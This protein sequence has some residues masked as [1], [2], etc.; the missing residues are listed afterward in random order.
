MSSSLLVFHILLTYVMGGVMWFVQ[1]AYYPNLAVVGR[2]AFI[3]YQRAHIRRINRVAWTMLVLE[4]AT[5]IL[6]VLNP[7]AAGFRVWLA[8]NMA[9]ILATWWSTWFVQVPLHFTL[10]CGWDEQAHQRLVRTNWFRTL[11]YTA[12]GGILCCVLWTMLRASA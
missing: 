5:G 8:V 10:E 9:L 12:R 2:D 7:P 11:S 1:L 6:I 4:L 3:H